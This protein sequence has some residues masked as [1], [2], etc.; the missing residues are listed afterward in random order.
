MRSPLASTFDGRR[1]AAYLQ[2]NF[3]LDR[4]AR[5]NIDVL[6]FILKSRRTGTEVVIVIRDVWELKFPLVIGLGASRIVR[7]GIVNLD[8]RARDCR[9]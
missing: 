4:H 1:R 3:Q 5:A 8:R 2:I 9:P 7:Y 6:G